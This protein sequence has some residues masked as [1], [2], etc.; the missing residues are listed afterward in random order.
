LRDVIELS[1]DHV[2]LVDASGGPVKLLVLDDWSL[3]PLDRSS[4][5]TCW[6]S[7]KSV[8]FASTLIT[9]Q[10][11]MERRHD[12]IGDPALSDEIP[13]RSQGAPDQ[14]AW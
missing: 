9:S 12:F 11:P 6:T 8:T 13:N 2:A 1:N 4:D 14:A 10:I 7:P 3:D 5:A